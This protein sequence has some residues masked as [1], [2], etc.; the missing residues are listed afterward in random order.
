MIDRKEK[1]RRS[2]DKIYSNSQRKRAIPPVPEL[3]GGPLVRVENDL[4]RI[5]DAYLKE[6]AYA[7]A[8]DLMKSEQSLEID[9]T[10]LQILGVALIN[11]EEQEQARETLLKAIQHL[12]KQLS[13]AF[14]NLATSYFESQDFDKALSAAQQAKEYHRTWCGP[15][16]NQIAVYCAQNDQSGLKGAVEAMKKAWPEWQTDLDLQERIQMDTTL[17]YLRE[18]KELR[19]LFPTW[20]KQ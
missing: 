16:V 7:D 2:L 18:M 20:L 14:T 1:T 13:V 5:A 8:R 6:G 15:W 10:A 12:R 19:R 3:P 4:I 17:G 9:S 11:L